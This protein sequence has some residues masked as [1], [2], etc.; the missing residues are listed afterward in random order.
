MKHA[1]IS[2][3]TLSDSGRF[4]FKD[5]EE[6]QHLLGLKRP[7]LSSIRSADS[8]T[9]SADSTGRFARSGEKSIV[10]GNKKKCSRCKK[11]LPISKFSAHHKQKNM[12]HGWC[13]SCR[14]KP[15]VG[16]VAVFKYSCHLCGK[17]GKLSF[18]RERKTVWTCYDCEMEKRR[19]I[20]DAR[21]YDA[22]IKAQLIR[23]RGEKCE[24]CGKAGKV[25]MHHIAEVRDGGKSTPDN[26][27]LV[28][29]PCHRKSHKKGFYTYLE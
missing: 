26:L 10:F 23:E 4:L 2:T 28:C 25:I 18:G 21:R 12:L 1:I 3:V 29:T 8:V 24:Q 17:G 9:T 15:V 16:K 7:V 5:A 14:E 19:K 6:N 13:N 27:E 11:N 22:G 20:K